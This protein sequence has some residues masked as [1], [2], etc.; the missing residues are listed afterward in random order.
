MVAT[1]FKRFNME[2]WAE[3]PVLVG[4]YPRFVSLQQPWEQEPVDVEWH[5]EYWCFSSPISQ[6]SFSVKSRIYY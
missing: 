2:I 6:L 4:F 5:K 3:N 1:R